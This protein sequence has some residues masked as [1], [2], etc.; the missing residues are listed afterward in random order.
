[1][2]MSLLGGFAA[3]ALVLAVVGIYGAVA[4]T[5][6]Q[7][8]GEIGVRMALGAQ[9]TDVLRMVLKQGM[10]PVIIG[11]GIGLAAT[12]AVGRPAADATLRNQGNRPIPAQPDGRDADRC[13]RSRMPHPGSTRHSRQPHP[14]APRRLN[15]KSLHSLD[16]VS[17][18]SSQPSPSARCFRPRQ[19]PHESIRS[20]SPSPSDPVAC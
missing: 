3:I 7:R 8:T 16:L 18:P 14:S 13:C 9:A 5:V 2:T 12:F 17:P 11:L 6:E 19:S 10:T 20:R 1:L 4:Y 15:M